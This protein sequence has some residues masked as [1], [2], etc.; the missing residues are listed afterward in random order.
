MATDAMRA[1]LAAG[2]AP[3]GQDASTRVA[4]DEREAYPREGWRREPQDWVRRAVVVHVSVDANGAP[5]GTFY[6]PNVP[7]KPDP[8]ACVPL[9]HWTDRISGQEMRYARKSFYR[10]APLNWRTGNAWRV[11]G[12]GKVRRAVARA[13][14]HV[15]RA[16]T[17]RATKYVRKAER[18][19]VSQAQQARRGKLNPG[20][21]YV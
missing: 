7:C 11:T 16:A 9:A 8:V 15:Q 4:M 1:A 5:S 18:L 3:L 14:A 2:R 20:K 12:Y 10:D 6:D 19:H 21:L 13:Q 17:Q